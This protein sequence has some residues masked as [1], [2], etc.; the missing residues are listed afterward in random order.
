M[1]FQAEVDESFYCLGVTNQRV[2]AA[3]KGKVIYVLDYAQAQC[4]Q[5]LEA[6]HAAV[7]ALQFHPLLPH[8]LFCL[9]SLPPP[10]PSFFTSPSFPP[11]AQ[12]TPPLAVSSDKSIILWDVLTASPLLQFAYSPR[13]HITPS[14]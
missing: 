9:F 10:S 8:L 1:M 7:N 13:D 11:S 5:V 3:G 12:L 14:Y 6:H 4:T 2:A